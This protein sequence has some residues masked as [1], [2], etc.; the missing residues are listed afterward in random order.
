MDEPEKFRSGIFG[1]EVE[2]MPFVSACKVAGRGC[3]VW[4]HPNGAWLGIRDAKRRFVVD[5]K[6]ARAAEV[7]RP[8][9]PLERTP[10]GDFRYGYYAR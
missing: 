7:I 3:T 9:L 6:P 1:I 10:S 8:V 4:R 5:Y 2:G